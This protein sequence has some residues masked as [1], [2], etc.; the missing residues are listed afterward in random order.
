MATKET[1]TVK[2]TKSAKV[3]KKVNE[4]KAQTVEVAKELKASKK[5]ETSMYEVPSFN[6]AGKEAGSVVLPEQ[7]FGVPVSKA[8]LAQAMRVYNHNRQANHG[9]TKTRG[10]VAGSTRK[11]FRQKGTGNAR[12]GS[13]MAPIFVGG[14]IALGPRTRKTE[15]D[16]PKKMK[17]AALI[18]AL[19]QKHQSARVSGVV[20]L[21]SVSGKTKDM[22][23]FVK[24]MDKKSL[25]IIDKDVNPLARRMVTNLNSVKLLSASQ[26]N[27]YEVIAHQHVLVTKEGIGALQARFEES[28]K[29]EVMANVK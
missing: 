1:K 17:T 18:A 16:L 13:I 5:V 4:P 3:V 9:N 20:S 22:S 2:E 8:L 10:E 14:G 11:I 21:A 26:I 25:L 24:A 27:V 29:E 6:L 12:H 7:I 15:L 19:S 23:I 28:A